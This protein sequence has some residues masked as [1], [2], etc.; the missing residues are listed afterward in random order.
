[1]TSSPYSSRYSLIALAAL[2]L[3]AVVLRWDVYPRTYFADE[4]IPKAVVQYMQDSGTLDTNWEHA[5]WRGD[6]AGGF[7][8]LKQYNFSS[9][10][11]ALY[12]FQWLCRN[13][14]MQDVSVLVIYRYFSVLCQLLAVLLV[15]ATTKKL[16]NNYAAIFSAGFLVITPQAVVDAHYARPESFVIFLV[17]LAVWLALKNC[18][19]KK[20]LIALCESIIWGIAFAC[21]F[22]FIPMLG[23]AFAGS[24]WALRRY[25]ILLLWP[26][27]FVVGIALSAPYILKDISGFLHGIALLRN[28]YVGAPVSGGWIQSYFPSGYVL[29]AYGM[30][31]FTLPVLVVMF[32]SFFLCTERKVKVFVGCSVFVS[33]LYWVVFSMQGVF[34]ERNLSHLLSLWAVLFGV[35]SSTLLSKMSGQ[36]AK[37]GM[38]LCI[39]LCLAWMLFLSWQIDRELFVGLERNKQAVALEEQILLKQYHAEKVKPFNVLKG[40]RALDGADATVIIRVS[41]PKLPEFLQVK[42]AF[43]GAGF[44]QI[45]Y[46]EMPL[47]FLPYNQL[48]INQLPPAYIYYQRTSSHR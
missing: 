46:R 22:S 28:Q 31:F 19:E 32:S 33:I 27:G 13:L 3:L 20:L 42:K 30:V 40:L 8:K 16:L 1:M 44:K 15:Y 25:A 4:L 2:L 48:Q 24:Y 39:A 17:A 26:L 35:G 37:A 29:A 36:L 38:V 21:K 34:F 5:D 11:T 23:L 41:L 18:T 9:Y 10:H 45:A 14:G 43:E 12:V 47:S 7:Y 6:F